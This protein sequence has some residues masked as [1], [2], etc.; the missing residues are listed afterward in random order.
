MDTV[1]IKDIKLEDL[2]DAEAAAEGA[3]LSTWFYQG[4]KNAEK[5]KALPK[6]SFYGTEGV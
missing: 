4:M 5:R 3:Y 2:G 6:V 1:E